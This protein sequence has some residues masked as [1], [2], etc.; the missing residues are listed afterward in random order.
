MKACDLVR[1]DAKVIILRA[2]RTLP[3]G[4][5]PWDALVMDRRDSPTPEEEFPRIAK[6]GEW[7]G[8]WATAVVLGS[9]S[10][11]GGSLIAHLTM[12]AF[13]RLF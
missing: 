3:P 7:F 4:G 9:L 10:V 2:A 11:A 5:S 1:S 8:F 6:A 13:R 12:A